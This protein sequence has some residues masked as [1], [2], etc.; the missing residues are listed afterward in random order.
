MKHTL[1]KRML[2]VIFVGY[3]PVFSATCE[4]CGAVGIKH[5]FYSKSKRFCSL[6]CSKLAKEDD[7]DDYNKDP[8]ILVS[9]FENF[10][11][12]VLFHIDFWSEPE[13][14]ESGGIILCYKFFTCSLWGLRI[15]TYQVSHIVRKRNFCLCGNKG[16]DQLS[17][18]YEA[19]Q[20]LCFCYTDIT[21]PL[22]LKS[23]ISSF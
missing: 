1:E 20:R 15:S 22:L 21:I 5:A 23:G 19:D 2:I 9:V 8:K 11:I 18:N 4:R 10:Q 6:N 13:K 7:F 17:S 3:L 16:V 12:Y 14:H